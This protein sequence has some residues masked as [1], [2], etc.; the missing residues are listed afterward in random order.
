MALFDARVKRGEPENWAPFHVMGWADT[1]TLSSEEQ[2]LNASRPI[3]V[4]LSGMAIAL[5]AVQR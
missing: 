4:T 3:F 2:R 1:V 5:R